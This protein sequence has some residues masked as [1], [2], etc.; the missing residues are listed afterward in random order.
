MTHVHHFVFCCSVSTGL[1]LHHIVSC[2]YVDMLF[3]IKKLKT[4]TKVKDPTQAKNQ[5]MAFSIFA[6]CRGAWNS[7]TFTLTSIVHNN[8]C[9]GKI[10]V[11]Q[12]C[13]LWMGIYFP[14]MVT[15]YYVFFSELQK[16]LIKILFFSKY[17]VSWNFIHFFRCSA[18]IK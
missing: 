12:L 6:L 15:K 1:V 18:Y 16:I 17:N 3:L 8:V 4:I 10:Y 11:L 7:S 5:F 13:L 9:F 2:E 14:K